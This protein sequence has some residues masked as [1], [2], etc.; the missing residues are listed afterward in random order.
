M[1]LGFFRNVEKGLGGVKGFLD[2]ISTYLEDDISI[3]DEIKQENKVSLSSSI[4]MKKKRNELLVEYLK[5]QEEIYYVLSKGNNKNRYSILKIKPKGQ[6]EKIQVN[7]EN[8]SKDVKVDTIMRL[9]NKKFIIDEKLTQNFKEKFTKEA[10]KIL[11]KQNKMLENYRQ[12]GEFYYVVDG[13]PS[14]IFLT[15]FNSKKVFEEP[16]LPDELRNKVS[17]GFILKYENGTYKVDEK[18]TEKNFEGKLKI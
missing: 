3:M 17:E 15:K 11:N 16:E 1:N 12:E 8:L 18:M 7:G 9:N 2:E 5:N 4:E 13:N 14:R 6:I 10:N